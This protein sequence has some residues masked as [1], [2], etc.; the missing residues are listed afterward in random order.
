MLARNY[1]KGVKWLPAVVIAQTGPVSYTVELADGHLIWKRHVDQLL[2]A[3]SCDN[4]GELVTIDP[5]LEIA[6]EYHDLS[7]NSS[8]PTLGNAQTE[9][10][11]SQGKETVPG[12]SQ[13]VPLSNQTPVKETVNVYHMAIS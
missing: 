4:L 10:L 6:S 13:S 3:N 9:T 2:A 11:P 1:G 5:Y 12:T 7:E 8:T